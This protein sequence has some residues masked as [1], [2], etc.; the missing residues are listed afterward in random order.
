MNYSPVEILITKVIYRSQRNFSGDLNRLGNK[1]R[2]ALI[3]Y[4]YP[5]TSSPD[6][7]IR[8]KR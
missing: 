7:R 3:I 5:F 1:L 6:N 8:V 4:Q 2:R